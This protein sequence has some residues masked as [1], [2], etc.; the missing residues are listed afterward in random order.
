MR[1]PP[2]KPIRGIITA[3]DLIGCY[4]HFWHGRTHPCEREDCQ[5]CHEGVPYRWHAY[6][7]AY[8]P[9]T[10]FHFIFEVTAQ[11][12]QHF[13]DY[14]DSIGTL[15]GCEFIATRMH[16]RPNGRVI[17]QTRPFDISKISL[18]QPPDMT[19]CLAI[20]WDLPAPEV[21]PGPINPSK[22]SPTIQHQP[23]KGDA[24]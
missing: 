17:I 13:A 3:H 16:N 5:P 6:F 18:P 1:T 14:R 11:A 8:Q 15:R 23:P 22:R 24:A 21:V 10:R 7:S 9:P 20:L 12:A 19:K 2:A 4:T